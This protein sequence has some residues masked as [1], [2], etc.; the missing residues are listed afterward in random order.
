M[1]M[2]T[3]AMAK[4]YADS[5]RLG[6]V[7]PAKVVLDVGLTDGSNFEFNATGIELKAG[8][9]YTVVT[10]SGSFNAV[11]NGVDGVLLYMGNTSLIDPDEGENTGENF[12]VFLNQDFGAWFGVAIDAN[13][14]GFIKVTTT[15]TIHPI[16]PKYLPG[17][18]L[19][20]VELSTTLT[21][22]VTFTEEENAALTAAF[23]GGVPVVM[24]FAMDGAGDNT[25]VFGRTAIEDIRGFSAVIAGAAVMLINDGTGWATV[26]E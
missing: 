7:E 4:A 19:P 22:G 10:E 2:I 23:E 12:C 8:E 21:N 9:T 18:C 17:V 20:V 26:V 6:H 15:E 16:D 3:L 5:Q 1:D 14:G 11:C 25:V 24:K 13:G